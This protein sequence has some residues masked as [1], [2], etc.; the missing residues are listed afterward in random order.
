MLGG[1]S[2]HVNDE[3]F[4]K[5]YLSESP[6]GGEKILALLARMEKEFAGVPSHK[7]AVENGKHVSLG[8]EAG[9]EDRQTDRQTH[10]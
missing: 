7:L 3:E 5:A 1:S 2:L 10:G 4:S 9:C 8:T 6:Y